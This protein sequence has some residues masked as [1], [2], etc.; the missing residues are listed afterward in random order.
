MHGFTISAA[1]KA[2]GAVVTPLDYTDRELTSVVTDSREVIPGC[3]FAA[4][5]GARS[6][7]HDFIPAVSQAGAA[8]VLCERVVPD[9]AAVQ[10]CVA[11][12]AAALKA[13][14]AA[15]RA[16]YAIPMVGISGSVGK[17]TAK[18]MIAAV[19]SRRLRTLKTEKNFNNELGVPK[20]LFR[21][22]P[23]HEAA[24]VE[25]GISDF[26]EMTR[27]AA[28]VRPDIAVYTKIGDAH[29]E[30]LGSR[31]GVL[32]AKT[33]LL[34]FMPPDGVV[35]CN[36]DDPLLASFDFG[37]KRVLCGVSPSCDVRA[38][39]IRHAG[40]EGTDFLLV[41]GEI[42]QPVHIPAYGEHLVSAALLAAGVG[43]TL[44]LTA[45]DIA[46]GIADYAAVGSR[47][48]I[49]ALDGVTVVDD[50]YN[51]NPTSAMSSIASLDNLPGRP[52]CILGD[53]LELGPD[54]Q[55]LHRMVGR[56]AAE[57]GNVV[58]AS[59]PLSRTLAESAG[60]TWFASKEELIAALPDHIQK[61]DVILVK[62]SHS[63]AFET[64]TAALERLFAPL[65]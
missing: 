59:G 8:A 23:E 36:G 52:V 9:C 56:F 45:S 3:L 60:G 4:L 58:L 5:T 31:E 26:G 33:E 18:E 22:E 29:L 11:D 41:S 32:R 53:M 2:T 46:A 6:D 13:M 48:R 20:T 14:A 65:R 54:A 35:V 47:G 10:L 63:M 37:K 44:G 7:G 55:A 49:L 19:L 43:L 42:R 62:A 15:Y 39:E 50:C 64:I 1:G 28:M 30:A 12:V 27:L 61:G 34:P 24:V 38:E 40:L 57:R 16:L 21:L 17:T 51:S 25:M